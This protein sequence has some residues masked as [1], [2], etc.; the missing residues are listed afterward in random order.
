MNLELRPF[1]VEAFNKMKNGCILCGSVGSGKSRTA[2]AY[3][4]TKI[5]GGSLCINGKG[6]FTEPKNKVDL[7]IITTAK[8]RDAKGWDKELSL[9]LLSRDPER[10]I[11]HTKVVVD[12]WN[13]IGKYAK[14]KNAMFIF[15][16]DR[17]TGTGK[18]S[19]TFLHI[20]KS[21]RW[22]ILS[23][24]P[25]D[26]WSDYMN[27]F[28][29]NG[30]Y[31]N[32]SEFRRMHCVYNPY[33]SY[34]VV[35]KYVNEK[36][37]RKCEAD[38]LILMEFER[39]VVE[40][41]EDVAVDYDRVKY[42]QVMKDRWD[43][44]ENEPIENVSKLCY[45]LRKVVNSDPSRTEVVK[46]ILS[47]Y[48]KCIIFYN[49]DYE[50]EILRKLGADISYT[51][52]E[53]NGHKHEEIPKTKKWL[54]LV[55]YSAGAEGWNCIQT[56]VIIFYSQNYSYKVMIQ[57]AGRINRMNTPYKD[58]YFYHV[59]SHAPIDNAIRTALK[60]KKTFNARKFVEGRA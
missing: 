36:R 28:I 37:L 44:Y 58:L 55:Q 43:P 57:A 32:K 34:P 33:L 59:R 18:W 20:S 14:V 15:D 4:Y 13:N 39:D 49:Y 5:A 26:T 47:H 17:V 23:A 31:K 16:E 52:A 38:I 11:N 1:Q 35:Q 41:H 12:S 25:A 50:V 22:I 51:V 21:N 53:W 42:K 7:Y 56:N 6:T 29:A 45:L 19:D 8:T 3:Y 46:Q 54:Y 40:H 10:S 27:V 9:Y 48:D 60:N 2:L 30:F 24:T